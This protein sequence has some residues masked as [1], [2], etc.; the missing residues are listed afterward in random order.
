[1]GYGYNKLSLYKMRQWSNGNK[2][3]IFASDIFAMFDTLFDAYQNKA[4]AKDLWDALEAKYFL[5]DVTRMIF[6]ATKCFSYKMID[7][8]PIVGQFNEIMYILDQ[9]TRMK[10]EIGDSI[11]VSSIIDKLP[12]SWKDYK[13]NLKHRK[14]ELSLEY[15]GQHFRIEEE[16]MLSDSKEEREYSL[17]SN[18]YMVEEGKSHYL[19]VK[20]GRERKK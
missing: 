12:T 1:M 16:I 19:D 15:L 4:T 2:M 13:R 5:E 17:T 18:M 3:T 9:F 14:E 6:L 8:R 7:F 20:I 10:M 11:S